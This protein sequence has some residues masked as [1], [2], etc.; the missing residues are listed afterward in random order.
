M[1]RQ[2]GGSGRSARP[3]L[4]RRWPGWAPGVG[5]DGAAGKMPVHSRGDK[6]GDR[7]ITMRWRWTT[8]KTRGAAP[9]TKTPRARRSSEDGDSS[10]TR[11]SGL[12]PRVLLELAKAALR[13]SCVLLGERGGERGKGG[14]W[15]PALRGT[16]AVRGALPSS[17]QVP[18]G[19][20][21]GAGR[22][23][24]LVQLTDAAWFCSRSAP[25]LGPPGVLTQ[26]IRSRKMSHAYLGD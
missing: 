10:G 20:A 17:W 4:K 8:P 11:P 3:S 22:G 19:G 9:R 26:A 13:R 5:S 7:T 2:R 23:P 1:T 16:Q 24:G 18:V 14:D 12:G 15:L 25:P 6:K 21:G